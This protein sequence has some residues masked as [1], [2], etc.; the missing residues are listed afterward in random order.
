MTAGE[1]MCAHKV[2]LVA[3]GGVFRSDLVDAA[4]S[5]PRDDVTEMTL[6]CSARGLEPI[7]EFAYTGRLEI[8]GDSVLPCYIA[9]Q[10]LEQS[11]I[12]SICSDMMVAQLGWLVSFTCDTPSH[13]FADVRELLRSNRVNLPQQ[14]E[15][16]AEE[17]SSSS[18]QS[19]LP[20]LTRVREECAELEATYCWMMEVLREVVPAAAEEELK[21]ELPKPVAEEELK[22]EIPK[23]VVEEK[24]QPEVPKIVVVKE[25]ED[26]DDVNPF[27]DEEEEVEAESVAQVESPKLNG[28]SVVADVSTEEAENPFGC[29]EEEVEEKVEE[30]PI[31]S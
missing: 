1:E 26:D 14:P 9:S 15:K 4:T 5:K 29:E 2:V 20:C 12:E 17:P 18:S 10:V 22:I 31:A 28:A 27:G 23:P 24:V 13:K 8:T 7:L 19:L 3:C 21:T 30:V 25:E 6:E 16:R 11:E